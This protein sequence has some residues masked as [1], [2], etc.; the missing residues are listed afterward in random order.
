MV[1]KRFG[2]GYTLDFGHWMAWVVMGAI[3]VLVGVGVLSRHRPPE[4][5]GGI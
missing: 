5:R 4:S 3:L 2:I 1:E